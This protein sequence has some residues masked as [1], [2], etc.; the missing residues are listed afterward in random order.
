[1]AV[2]LFLSYLLQLNDL[3]RIYIPALVILFLFLHTDGQGSDMTFF[4]HPNRVEEDSLSRS[5]A[6]EYE[7]KGMFSISREI[8][9]KSLTELNNIGQSNSTE[10]ARLLFEL[11]ELYLDRKEYAIASDF[12]SEAEDIIDKTGKARQNQFY[13]Q[14]KLKQAFTEVKLDNH[15]SAIVNSNQ[16]RTILEDSL[17]INHPATLNIVLQIAEIYTEIESYSKARCKLY[18]LSN[19]FNFTSSASSPIKLTVLNPEDSYR[20]SRRPVSCF[21]TSS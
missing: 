15:L 4:K 6:R 11:G 7:S 5:T 21:F 18:G 1:M 10:F 9:I 20:S 13:I 3:Q 19:C 17:G 16:I 8:L 2:N 12:F 14:L